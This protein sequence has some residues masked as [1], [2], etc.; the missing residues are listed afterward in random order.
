MTE[1]LTER[2]R[3]RSWTPDDLD[4]LH[5]IWGDPQVIWWGENKSIDESR[6]ML[7]KLIEHRGIWPG[8]MEWFAIT[9]R[10]DPQV[11]GDVLLQPARFIEGPEIGWHMH[12]DAWGRGYATEGAR[13]V[14]EHSFTTLGL[15]AVHAVVETSN[16][17]SLRVVEKLGMT[18]VKELTYADLPHVHFMRRSPGQS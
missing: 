13:A 12:R 15:D 1:L 17:P 10:D 9:R 6:R 8:G 11:I 3:L 18:R 7:E 2:L 14:I 5:A 16:A 4:A